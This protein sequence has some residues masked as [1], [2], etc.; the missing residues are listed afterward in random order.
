MKPAAPEACFP[1]S[2]SF[3]WAWLG[4][5]TWISPLPVLHRLGKATELTQRQNPY[6]QP[7]GVLTSST[8]CNR[9]F[10]SAT[11]PREENRT[12]EALPKARGR[13]PFP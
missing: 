7:L 8:R 12:L 11:F 10:S 9:H 2:R 13:P 5:L 6:S 3:Q 1:F 4:Y